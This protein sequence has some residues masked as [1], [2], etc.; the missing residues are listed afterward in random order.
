MRNQ[1]GIEVTPRLSIPGPFSLSLTL[2]MGQ[3]FRWRPF[4]D[5]WFSGVVGPHLFHVRQI[6]GGIEYEAASLPRH[7]DAPDEC[8]RR[9]FRLDD[10]I[11]VIYASIARD[12]KIAT[13]MRDFPGLRLL[14]QEPWECLAAQFCAERTDVEYIGESLEQAAKLIGT[15]L[16]LGEDIRYTFP[17]PR[18]VESDHRLAHLSWK[19]LLGSR[20][21]WDLNAIAKQAYAGEIDWN[22][23]RLQPYPD[24]RISLL[25]FAGVSDKIADCIA[26]FALDKLEAFPVD[27]WV[28]RAIIEAYPEWGFPERSDPSGQELAAASHRAQQMF[29]KYAGYANQYLFY[30]RRQYGEEP[31]PF[32]T[33]WRGK[34]RIV[35]PTDRQIDDHYLDDLRHEYLKAKYSRVD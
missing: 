14:R 13:I 30:W 18:Q 4:G 2:T 16:R 3:A 27:R 31:L 32:G 20:L 9:Y 10:D 6:D 34:F 33:R 5:G 23:L 12:P 21:A 24:V 25:Q 19:W 15:E 8:L 22:D 28:W 7:V 29:G 26:L 17:T 1:R 35:P 11:D